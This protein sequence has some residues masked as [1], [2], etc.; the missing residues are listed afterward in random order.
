MLSPR[1]LRTHLARWVPEAVKAPFR[2]RL[3]GYGATGLA[4]G[5]IGPAGDVVECEIA[6][7]R[8]RAPGV[9]RDD[10]A[11]H[12]VDNADSIDEMHS[13]V[14]AARERGGLLMDVG[15]ARG[16][17]SAVYCL[18]AEGATAVAYEPAPGQARDAE[19]LAEMNGVA[20]RIRV[21]RAAVGTTPGTM[22]GRE[23]ALGLIDLTPADAAGTFDVE[24]TTL[25]EEAARLGTPA[26]VK[27][28]VEGFELEVLR[29]ATGLLRDH[30]PLLLLE[31]HLD[32]LERR[33][34]RITEVTAL[35]DGFGY[36]FETSAGKPL[37]VRAVHGSPNAVLR[38]V[39]R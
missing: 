15:A 23:D 13:V 16:L 4:R 26:V 30:R 38:V 33:G 9:A 21:R 28:D 34:V 12:L 25:D 11:Y 7:V 10:L 5:S 37:P 22:R 17:I 31:L 29:G 27:I 3:F 6:G 19:Q 39:A 32:L 35:L 36:R 1:W 24:M 18:A 14:R 20:D 8:F 2:A